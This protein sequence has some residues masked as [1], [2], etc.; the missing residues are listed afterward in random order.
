MNTTILSSNLQVNPDH[1]IASTIG[2]NAFAGDFLVVPSY[3]EGFKQ[4]GSPRY[5]SRQINVGTITNENFVEF[6]EL[7]YT[8]KLRTDPCKELYCPKCGAR[9][10]GNGVSYVRLKHI[11]YGSTYQTL[12]VEVKRYRCSSEHCEYSCTEKIPFQVGGHRI[13]V[14]AY[15]EIYRLLETKGSKTSLKALSFETGVDAKIIRA[16]DKQRLY[17]KYT[18]NGEGKKLLPPRRQ[19]R[20]LG[21]DEFLLHSLDRSDK[22][23]TFIMDMETGEVLWVAHSKTKEAIREFARYVGTEWLKGVEALACDM[24]ADFYEALREFNPNIKQVF[25]HFHLVKNL[26]DKVITPTRIAIK[27]EMEKK[28]DEKGLKAITGSKY[29]LTSSRRRLKE[30]D[31][32]AE[33]WKD[34]DAKEHLFNGVQKK[35][36]K[37]GRTERYQELLHLNEDLF[38]IDMLKDYLD[39]AYKCYSK[40]AMNAVILAAIDICEAS[41]NTH[42]QWFGKMLMNHLDGITNFGEFRLTSGKV[43]GTVRKIKFIRALGFGYPDDDYFFLKIIDG[44]RKNPRKNGSVQIN[45]G[46]TILYSI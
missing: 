28:A 8:G 11:T 27:D 18:E 41:A 23:A 32:I 29:L 6:S 45:V 38:V 39:E 2:P 21:V 3:C 44:T 25:D 5:D 16:I 1:V 37:G 17:D 42:I 13:T 40:G 35:A 33:N 7:T 22:F 24:N 26:N 30:R 9:L 43:E 15:H 10:H 12:E 31:N 34:E 4:I 14:A 20:I 36:P 19:A 46:S